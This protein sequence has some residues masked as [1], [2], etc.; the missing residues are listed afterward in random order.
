M[1]TRKPSRTAYFGTRPFSE[2]RVRAAK[3]RV[4]GRISRMPRS[5]GPGSFAPI[6][7][8]RGRFNAFQK[9]TSLFE[10]SLASLAVMSSD[11]EG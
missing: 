9:R 3:V 10:A 4:R 6:P 7:D 8:L 1:L 5:Y 11:H 2:L